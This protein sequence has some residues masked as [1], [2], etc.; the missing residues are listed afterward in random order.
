MS[1][2]STIPAPIMAQPVVVVGGPTGPSGGPTGSVGA[3]GPTGSAASFT[4]PTGRTG[5]PGTGP[6]GPTGAGAFT[7]PTGRTGPPGLGVTGPTGV[8][9]PQGMTGSQGP[10]GPGNFAQTNVAAPAGNIGGTN[11]MMGLA[12]YLTPTHSG[13]VVFSVG[14]VTQNTT[15]SGGVQ[16]QA[17]YGTG[18]APVNGTGASGASAGAVPNVIPGSTTAQ[19]GFSIVGVVSGLAIGTTYWFDISIMATGAGGGAYVKNVYAACVEL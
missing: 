3:T 11:T 12:V 1:T 13:N 5:P 18:T 4:G 9:G 17:R 2:Q 7:G 10:L 6:T 8:T 19:V 16:I 14:G 15:A